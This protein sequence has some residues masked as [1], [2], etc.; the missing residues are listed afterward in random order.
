MKFLKLQGDG[1]RFDSAWREIYRSQY[2]DLP[3][4]EK[5]FLA[6]LTHEKQ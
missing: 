1:A 4:F 6:Y 5:K 3:A 2:S